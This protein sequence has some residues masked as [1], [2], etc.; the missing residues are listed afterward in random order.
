ML[1]DLQKHDLGIVRSES[2]HFVIGSALALVFVLFRIEGVGYGEHYPAG[3]GIRAF[4]QAYVLDVHPP[5]LV[6]GVEDVIGCK[7]YLQAFPQKIAAHGEV[8]A[9]L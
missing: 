8:N 7:S 9:P 1:N 5:A 4:I 3:I 6:A 2:F